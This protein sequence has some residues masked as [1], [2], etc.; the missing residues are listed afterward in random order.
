MKSTLRLLTISVFIA[1]MV[2]VP[3]HSLSAQEGSAGKLVMFADTA[4]FAGG[5]QPRNCFAMNRFKPGEPAGFRVSVID[6]ATGQP[7]KDTTVVVHLS[8]GGRTEDVPA[9]FRGAPGTGGPIIENMWSAKWM[10]PKDA[11]TGVVKVSITA[12]DKS[13]R[14]ATWEPWPN[15]ATQVTIVNE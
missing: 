15:P 9:R 2:A 12:K 14:S 3:G 13:G 7:A 10:V 8:Y 1:G 4:L 6:G 5:G 11:P